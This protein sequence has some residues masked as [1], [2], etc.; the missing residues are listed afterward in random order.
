MVDVLCLSKNLVMSWLQ[1]VVSVLSLHS[2][3]LVSF[4]KSN[5]DGCNNIVHAYFSNLQL[6]FSRRRMQH[7]AGYFCDAFLFRIGS[8]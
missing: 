5:V 6:N 8:C 3:C 7:V 2:R 1:P 4:L